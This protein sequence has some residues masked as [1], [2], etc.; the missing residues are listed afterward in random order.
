MPPECLPARDAWRNVH[1]VTPRGP[2]GRA[3]Q[4]ESPKR[5]HSTLRRDQPSGAVQEIS[6][7]LL[8]G[9][10]AWH[11]QSPQRRA[12]RGAGPGTSVQEISC[13]LRGAA[14]RGTGNRRNG[15]LCGVPRDLSFTSSWRNRPR[16]APELLRPPRSP[17]ASQ[18]RGAC[19][20]SSWRNRPRAAP[21]LLRP[22]PKP[23][24]FTSSW[25]MFHKLVAQSPRGDSLQSLAPPM[26]DVK[27]EPR[28]L[29]R[30]SG[31]DLEEHSLSKNE[32]TA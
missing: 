1:R 11:R 14:R 18:A 15:G 17:S 23:E 7:T 3:V 12:L 21:E 8:G 19:F 31:A 2:G 5:R 20:T 22:P 24:R 32:V 29:T 16:A 25:S 26:A 28:D 30:Q 27:K 4:R 10:T 9:S 13:T 6:C